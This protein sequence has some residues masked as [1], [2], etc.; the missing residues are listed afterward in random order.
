ME[1]KTSPQRVRLFTFT[2][3]LKM[4]EGPEDSEFEIPLLPNYSK[5]AVECD[6]NS[7]IS[8]IRKKFGFLKRQRCFF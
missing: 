4:S 6:R 5:F 7:K 8:P 3:K 1:G 2:C